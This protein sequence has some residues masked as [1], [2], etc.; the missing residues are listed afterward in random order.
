MPESPRV[1]VTRRAEQAGSFCERLRSTGM[2]PVLFPTIQ[3]LPLPAKDLDEALADCGRFEWLIFSSSNVVDFFYQR[4]AALAWTGQLPRTAVVG[5][6]TARHLAQRQIQ[7]DF[8]PEQ[9]TGQALAEG[10]GDLRDKAVLLPRAQQGRPEIVTALEAQGA[11]VTEIALY[12]T[13]TA[14]PTSED[15]AKLAAGYE[16]LTF[17]SPSS[18]QGFLEICRG[19]VDDTAV[20][21]CI[22]PVTAEAARA[23][24]LAVSLM[25]EEYTTE[26]LVRL[27]AAH[28]Q[29]PGTFKVPSN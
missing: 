24:G 14:V 28:F 18:V 27:L 11:L 2:T 5:S 23:A 1:V 15:L 12:D 8:I 29:L 10:L 4:V 13:V 3:L 9:F 6:A 20:I 22:G 17:A 7:P 25:P 16:A 26:G 19:D 21:A